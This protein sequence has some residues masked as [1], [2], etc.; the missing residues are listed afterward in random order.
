VHA[1]AGAAC[2]TVNVRVA[3]VTVPVRAA[4][5]LAAIV[6]ATEPLPLPLAPDVM[7]IHEA[8]LT[9]AVQLQPAVAVTA[10]GLIG[11]PVG[12]TSRLAG[13]ISYMHVG[14]GGG[15]GGAG[16]AC[17]TVNARL[18]IVTVPV[19]AAPVLAAIVIA[20]EPFPLPLV[21]DVMVIHEALLTA[22]VQLQPAGAVTATGLMA[23]PVAVTSRLAGMIS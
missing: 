7:V 4:P 2:V 1:G 21:P 19:R 5:V 8:L 14:A 9:A 15:G 6:I 3:I 13:L 22:A 16:A 17:V 20:T 18:A 12:A 23:P 11:P 10:T